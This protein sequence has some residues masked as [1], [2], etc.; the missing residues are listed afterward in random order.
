MMPPADTNEEWIEVPHGTSSSPTKLIIQETFPCGAVVSV[1]KKICNE[2][3][4]I[5]KVLIQEQNSDGVEFWMRS[6]SIPGIRSILDRLAPPK[7]SWQQALF[8]SGNK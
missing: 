7:K 1:R 4:T 8:G 6:D 5:Y 3:C 2:N